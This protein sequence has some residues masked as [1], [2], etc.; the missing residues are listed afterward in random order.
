MV[1]KEKVL[2]TA[3]EGLVAVLKSGP[4]ALGKLSRSPGRAMISMH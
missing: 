2:E 3:A 4:N 1:S